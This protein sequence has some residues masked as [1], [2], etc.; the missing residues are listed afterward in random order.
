MKTISLAELAQ[1][2]GAT[3]QGDGEQQINGVAGIPE[4]DAEK[5]TFLNDKKYAKQLASCQAAAVILKPEFAELYQGSCLL[6]DNPYLAYALAAQVLDT[7]PN[8]ANGIASD[9]FIH[10][11]AQIDP[12]ANIASGATVC[13]GAVVGAGSQ[14]ASGAYIGENTEV[15][16]GCKIYANAT[17]YHNCQLGDDCIIHSGAVIGSDGFGFAND[18][19]QWVKIPQVGRVVIE[20]NVEIG[21]NTSIDRG[22]IKDTLIRQGVKIDNLVHIAHNVEVD[23]N[24]A[25]AGGVIMAGSTYIGKRCTLAGGVALNGHIQ[26]ADDV[27]VTGFSMVTKSLPEA[28]VYSSGQPATTNKEWRRN[29]V[30]LRQVESLFDRVKELEKQLAE[31][32][33]SED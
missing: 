5:V 12:T 1:R 10:E 26:L 24:T 22:T 13:A 16:K 25:I 28:G 4:A 30:K 2:I 32:K 8:I 23:E 18:K 7:T 6:A 11:S 27:H 14:I 15:G 3:L 31:L 21:S 33:T 17:L 9:A 20:D 19:G 29:T